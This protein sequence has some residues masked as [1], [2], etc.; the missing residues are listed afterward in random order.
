[1]IAGL[2]AGAVLAQQNT[3]VLH[4]PVTLTVPG[5]EGVAPS[6]L[7]A[8]LAL[9]GVLALFWLA[10]MFDLAILRGH[11]RRRDA[12]LR[13]KDQEIMRIKSEAF[14]Q[15]Q[16]ALNDIRARLDKVTLELS[17]MM[18]RFDA[19]VSLKSARVMRED[20]RTIAPERSDER[21]GVTD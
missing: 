7:R 17:A 8:F 19:G 15:Q 14:D 18:A 2:I 5:L 6:Y 10:G 13:A 11:V 9:G 4:A 21:V 16:P 20:M 1:L 3:A 12:L